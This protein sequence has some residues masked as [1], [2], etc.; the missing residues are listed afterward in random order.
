MSR[1][2]LTYVTHHA[3]IEC[4]AHVGSREDP[5]REGVRLAGATSPRM[6]VLEGGKAMIP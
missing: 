1:I 5:G 3:H 4:L 6:G 2:V